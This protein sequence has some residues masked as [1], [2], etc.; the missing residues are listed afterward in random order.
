MHVRW[1]HSESCPGHSMTSVHG[2]SGPPSSEPPSSLLPASVL[3][4]SS[5]AAT[6]VHHSRCLWARPGLMI[7]LHSRSPPTHKDRSKSESARASSVLPWGKGHRLK[8]RHRNMDRDLWADRHRARRATKGSLAIIGGWALLHTKTHTRRTICDKPVTE[9]IC[10]RPRE[11]VVD[12]I[13]SNL[14]H[15]AAR[16]KM[17][18]SLAADRQVRFNN[19]AWNPPGHGAAGR[20]S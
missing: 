19:H 12:L 7:R 13:A 10:R 15:L 8:R 9:M 5:G 16:L 17:S 18:P 4:L 14:Q 20:W 6:S 11:A 3:A 1:A 2:A